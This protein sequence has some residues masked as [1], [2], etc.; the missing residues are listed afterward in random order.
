[1]FLFF[2]LCTLHP[3]HSTAI[4]CWTGVGPASSVSGWV[5]S[6]DDDDKQVTKYWYQPNDVVIKN[7]KELCS[8]VVECSGG[9]D[10]CHIKTKKSDPSNYVAKCCKKK[11]NW[12]GK[13]DTCDDDASSSDTWYLK[14]CEEN[15]CNMLPSTSSFV[16][17][18]QLI[19]ETVK[20]AN[21]TEYINFECLQTCSCKN[22]FRDVG[23]SPWYYSEYNYFFFGFLSCLA[24]PLATYISNCKSDRRSTSTS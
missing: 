20:S 2:L 18:V 8:A 10:A 17:R 24:Y 16:R 4:N 11:T 23:D 13:E 22:D 15:G 19:N 7:I 12:R 5:V 3:L 1:M 14:T 6:G 9:S 21:D